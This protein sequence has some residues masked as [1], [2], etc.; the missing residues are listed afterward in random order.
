MPIHLKAATSAKEKDLVYRLRHKVFVEEEARFE[1]P[2]DRILD[3]YDTLEENVNF[4][5]MEGGEVVGSLRITIENEVGLPALEHYDF[6]PL[7]NSK[8]PGLFANIGWLCISKD[9][10]S[11]RGILAA[12]FKMAVRESKKKGVQ[13]LIAPLHPPLFPLLKRFGARAIDKEFFSEELRVSMIPIHI[14]YNDLP[15]GLREFSQDPAIILFGDTNERRI[16][17]QGEKII[18]KGEI[19][20]EAFLIMRGAVEVVLREDCRQ[21]SRK[22]YNVGENG[23]GRGNPLLGQGQVFGELSLLD[24]GPRTADVIGHSKEVDVMV[25]NRDYFAEQLRSGGEKAVALCKILANRL[26]KQL[27]GDY[28][29]NESRE[30]LIATIALDASLGATQDV[31]LLWLAGQCAVHVKELEKIMARW[32]KKHIVAPSNGHAIKIIEPGRLEEKIIWR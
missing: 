7:I 14:D 30:A 2:S 20:T 9:Y 31:N 18:A 3:F 17:R 28:L 26:R 10:R 1:H 12:L 11:H 27:E 5:A 22:G 15:P 19:G 4:I 32:A 23:G 16:Y 6:M 8:K 29:Q 25:W 13:H 24:D 21:T